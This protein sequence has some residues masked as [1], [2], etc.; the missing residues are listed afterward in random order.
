[1]ST[2]SLPGPIHA[3]PVDDDR[4]KLRKQVDKL[5]RENEDLRLE[6]QKL[7]MENR[8]TIAAAANIKKW[9]APLYDSLR[10]LNGEFEAMDLHDAPVGPGQPPPSGHVQTSGLHPKFSAALTR[11]DGK[12]H[13]VLKLLIDMGPM[14]MAGISA[15]VGG[16]LNTLYECTAHLGKLGL[17]KK[18]DKKFMLKED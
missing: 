17:I 16:R 2:H 15:A 1:M 13:E 7:Q 8:R 12:N 14:T 3:I 4:E 9:T 5:Q 11:L 6:N 10:M 18:Q